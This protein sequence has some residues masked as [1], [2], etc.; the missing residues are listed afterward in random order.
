MTTQIVIGAGEVGRAIS[1]VLRIRA[2]DLEG[3]GGPADV[4]HVCFPWSPAF[5]ADVDRYRCETGASLV[6]VHSTVP[7]GT[8]RAL[9]AVHSPVTGRHPDLAESVRTFVKFFGGRQAPEAAALFDAVGVRTEVVPDPETTEAG[10]LWQ[11]LQFGMLVALQKEGYRW[12][13]GL[14]ADPEVAYAHMNRAYSEGYAALGE[15]FRLLVLREMPG[16]I[17]GHC[18]IP[19]ARLT[20]D[21]IA[22][23]LTAL[24]GSWAVAP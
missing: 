14:G 21:P 1:D 20:D 8:C 10:K 5:A 18:V 9:D 13:R 22:R 17:G 7:V 15:P 16:P 2:Y 6:I 12:M 24:D 4:L 23:L 3:P 19:N 11:T